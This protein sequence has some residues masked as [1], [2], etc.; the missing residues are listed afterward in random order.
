M[1]GYVTQHSLGRQKSKDFVAPAFV[2]SQLHLVEPTEV[3]PLPTPVPPPIAGLASHFLR[4]HQL[5]YIFGHPLAGKTYSAQRLKE[6]L[7]FFHGATVTI[8]DVN[9]YLEADNGE[10][11]LLRD[12][13]DFFYGEDDGCEED[14]GSPNSVKSAKNVRVG[15]YALLYCCYVGNTTISKWSAH[16]K[17]NRRFIKNRVEEELD[18]SVSFIEFK[19]NHMMEEH[20]EFKDR[21]CKHRGLK[22]EELERRIVDYEQNH[23]SLQDDGT[24]DD[25]GYIQIT[26]F[27][28][29]CANKVMQDFLGSR[30]THFLGCI[31]PYKRVIYLSRHGQSEYNVE[32]KIGGDSGLSPLGSAYSKRLAVF[33]QHVVSGDASDF[34]CATLDLD[35]SSVFALHESLI[36]RDGVLFAKGDWK[37]TGE[38][39]AVRDGMELVQLQRGSDELFEEAPSTVAEVVA[40]AK[41]GLASGAR[42]TLAFVQRPAGPFKP[43]KARLWTSSMRR[44]HETAQHIAHPIITFPDGQVWEQLRHQVHRSLDEVFAGEFEGL[45]Y[46]QIKERQPDEASLRKKDKLGYRYPRGESYYDVIARLEQPMLRAETLREP[47]LIVGHQAVLRMVYAFLTGL[48]RESAVDISIPH[49]AVT[50]LEFDATGERREKRFHVGPFKLGDDGQKNL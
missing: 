2:E 5:G 16:S 11:D 23:V 42:T 44:T 32:Q 48:P 7:R 47:L 4:H 28:R 37:A 12:M 50:R 10:A 17:G 49:H 40:I 36:A 21:L 1:S 27:T 39:D 41:A 35:E 45:T 30:V 31:H 33:A 14:P 3:N 18:A 34:A 25:L 38:Q 22:P 46:E 19:A 29:I 13:H 24:E 20:Q 43:S 26:N 6:Y 9:S 8:F 15:K